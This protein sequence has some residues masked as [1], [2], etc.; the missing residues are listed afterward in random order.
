MV[1]RIVDTIPKLNKTVACIGYFDGVHKGHQQLISNT[2]KRSNELKV[3][4]A[5][6]CFDP[7]PLDVITSK[8]NPHIM[9][10]KN[11]INK[12]KEFGID[13]VYVIKFTKS[14][15]QSKAEDFINKYLNKMNIVELVCGFDFSF[16]YKGLGND[17]LLKKLGNFN[18]YVVEEFKYYG[19]KISSTRIRK[20]ILDARFDMVNRLL[21]WDYYIEL[22]V[23]DVKSYRNKYL[24]ECKLKDKQGILPSKLFKCKDYYIDNSKVY[25]KSDI[26]LEVKEP[27][28]IVFEN[29]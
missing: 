20:A 15:M 4:S 5:L 19:K 2:I 26:K 11:R 3:E 18:V 24:L 17:K 29:E 27:L 12:I 10:L 16:G 28:V 9:S 14:F 25:I 21:G 22:V 1:Y 23:D 8:K 6:I 13:N 7:D